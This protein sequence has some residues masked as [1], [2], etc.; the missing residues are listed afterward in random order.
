MEGTKASGAYLGTIRE[1]TDEKKIR[2][3][4]AEEID[5]TLEHRP[6]SA[7]YSGCL[8]ISWEEK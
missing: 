3:N 7:A 8:T 5:H 1:L 4:G 6:G 2:L